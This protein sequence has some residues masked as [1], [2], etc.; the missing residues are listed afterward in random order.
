MMTRHLR[1]FLW[2]AHA[3]RHRADANL[4]GQPL[5]GLLLDFLGRT[6]GK[7]LESF[8]WRTETPYV[9]A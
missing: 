2:E 1:G 7:G 8:K 5:R 6:I 3:L 9:R 4:Y